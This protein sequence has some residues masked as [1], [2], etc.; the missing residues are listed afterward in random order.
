MG[1]IA[2]KPLFWFSRSVVRAALEGYLNPE[3]AG[4]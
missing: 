1:A 4:R 3:A 2:F